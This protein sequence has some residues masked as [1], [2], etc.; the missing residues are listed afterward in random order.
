[1]TREE[2]ARLIQLA[3][4]RRAL[5]A[6]VGVSP[7]TLRNYTEGRQIPGEMAERLRAAAEKNQAG[8]G[9]VECGSG[10]TEPSKA[11]G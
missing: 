11:A 6:K 1:M 8:P 4:S 5:A 10:V 3:G 7:S 2:L 9:V